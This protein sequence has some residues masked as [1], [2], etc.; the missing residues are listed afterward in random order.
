VA[1][2]VQL[3]TPLEVAAARAVPADLPGHRLEELVDLRVGELPAGAVLGDRARGGGVEAA[4]P[5]LVLHPVLDVRERRAAVDG[6][7]VRPHAAGDPDL[8]EAEGP[9]RAVGGDNR[10]GDRDGRGGEVHDHPLSAP[11]MKPRT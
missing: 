9:E 6:L 3:V 2:A 11:D 4:D 5:A 1:E 10:G 7:P 8:V